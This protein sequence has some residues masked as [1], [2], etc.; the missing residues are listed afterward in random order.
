[1][2]KRGPKPKRP[3]GLHV[4]R[5]GYL[6]GNID[7]R[8]RLAHVA[9]WERVHGRVPAGFQVH[10]V[11]GDKQDNRLDNLRLVSPTEH[12][13][14]HSGCELRGDRWWKPCGICGEFK[15]IGPDDW[16]LS[17][18]GYP[19]YGRCRPCHITKVVRAKQLRKLR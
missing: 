9:V 8:L 3:D 11:N 6:R 12:K 18:N 5:A 15:P 19:L 14:I 2:G 4:T 1:M 17:P 7:G 10:H 16:Y 13:R